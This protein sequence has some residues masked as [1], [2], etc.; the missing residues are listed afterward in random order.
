MDPLT[1]PLMQPTDEL[2]WKQVGLFEKLDSLESA[3]QSFPSK[4]SFSNFPSV[5]AMTSVEQASPASKPD[6]PGP[7]RSSLDPL[8]VP[9]R[10]QVGLHKA[11]STQRQ[12]SC[13]RKAWKSSRRSKRL[14]LGDGVGFENLVLMSSCSL[15][16][17]FSYKPL[18]PQPLEDW[19]KSKWVPVL[20]Y[21]PQVQY[22]KKGWFAFTVTLQMMP[23]FY[24][25]L[26]GSTEE[27]A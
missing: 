9:L 23:P 21:L 12:A 24:F 19:L 7:D 25:L 2:I 16:G 27:V 10:A 8:S 26:S 20:G 6:P 3:R 5:P 11:A 1:Y 17:R 22:L 15:V 4:P 18:S 13:G 14:V